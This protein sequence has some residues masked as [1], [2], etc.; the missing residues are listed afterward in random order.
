M[1]CCRSPD[2]FNW[3]LISGWLLCCLDTG[4]RVPHCAPAVPAW[5]KHSDQ[6]IRG[7]AFLFQALQSWTRLIADC[8]QCAQRLSAISMVFQPIDCCHCGVFYLSCLAKRLCRWKRCVLLIVV[9]VKV[10]A[11]QRMARH[12]N[13]ARRILRHVCHC[14]RIQYS[15]FDMGSGPAIQHAHWI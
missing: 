9:A 8:W 12:S 15:L 13:Q 3:E 11:S 6:G 14:T 7:I 4:C 1:P 10:C 2:K 5:P